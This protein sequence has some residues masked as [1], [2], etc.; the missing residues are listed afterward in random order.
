MD[1]LPVLR[2]DSLIVV[3]SHTAAKEEIAALSAE[4]ALRGS[5]T[6][7]DGGNCFPFYRFARLIRSKTFE[8]A[9]AVKRLFIRR[10][11]TCYQMQELLSSTPALDQPYLIL[12][13][14][15][16]FYD[17]QIPEREVR[18][19]LDACLVEV[20]RLAMTARVIISLSPSRLP[21]RAFLAE[22]IC[23]SADQTFILDAPAPEFVQPELF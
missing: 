17:E 15:A 4:L 7:L 2:K 23:Q 22:Q 12:N 8:G 18:R 1:I 6:V 11:F 19:L 13:L 9:V 20:K 16:T 21:E 10:A 3:S 5:V 14:L